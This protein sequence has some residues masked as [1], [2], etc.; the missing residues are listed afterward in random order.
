MYIIHVGSQFRCVFG[1]SVIDGRFAAITRT[2]HVL[3]NVCMFMS[4]LCAVGKAY[5]K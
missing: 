2:V 4:C 1:V 3:R 5:E